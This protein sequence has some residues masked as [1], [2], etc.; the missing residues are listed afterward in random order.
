MNTT[1]P[2]TQGPSLAP[3]LAPAG[4]PTVLGATMAPTSAPDPTMA[5]TTV[6]VPVAVPAQLA[7]AVDAARLPRGTGLLVLLGAGICV[8]ACLGKTLAGLPFAA[9]ALQVLGLVYLVQAAARR[10][11]QL[12]PW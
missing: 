8:V 1:A 3:T 7:R 4:G 6:A 11:G 5:P 10:G 9:Q 2:P 12:L